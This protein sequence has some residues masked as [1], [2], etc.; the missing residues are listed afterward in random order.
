MSCKNVIKRKLVR[1][2]GLAYLVI[3]EQLKQYHDRKKWTKEQRVHMKVYKLNIPKDTKPTHNK[4][5]AN[6]ITLIY[7]S[8]FTYYIGKTQ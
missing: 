6:E 5:N 7:M 2:P 4:R 8:F 1:D 3:K